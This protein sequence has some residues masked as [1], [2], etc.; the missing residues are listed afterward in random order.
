MNKKNVKSYT[1]ITQTQKDPTQKDPTQKGTI[2]S[3]LNADPCLWLLQMCIHVGIKVGEGQETSKEP[4]RIEG[5]GKKD[6][7]TKQ[8]GRYNRERG[9]EGQWDSTVVKVLAAKSD[10]LS[11]IPRTQHGGRREP[12]PACWPLASTHELCNTS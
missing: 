2:C 11:S 12:A 3:P 4:S 10:D 6:N 7:R 1:E 9:V 8:K 5:E